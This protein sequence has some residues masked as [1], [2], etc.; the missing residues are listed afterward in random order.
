[1]LNIVKASGYGVAWIVWETG[2]LLP[3]QSSGT[4]LQSGISGYVFSND[5]DLT[6][7]VYKI[8]CV[9][10]RPL[11]LQIRFGEDISNGFWVISVALLIWYRWTKQIKEELCF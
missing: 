5:V 7:E 9:C 11:K 2:G 10:N 8:K 1:M 4:S 6:G 3:A